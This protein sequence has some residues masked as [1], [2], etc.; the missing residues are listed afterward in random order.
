MDIDAYAAAHRGEWDRL[1]ALSRGSRPLDGA[2]A[3]ELVALYQRVATQLSVV[4]SAVPDAVVVGHL[5]SLLA[6]ARGAIAGPRVPA[7][8]EILFF[9]TD[10]FPAAVYR[11]RRWWVPTALLSL[12]GAVLMGWYVYANPSAQSQ[13]ASVDAVRGLVRPGGEFESYYTNF[14][15][16]SFGFEVWVN[17][18][19]VAA[20]TLFGGILLGVPVFIGLYDNMMNAGVQGGFM[21]AHGRL[22]VFLSLIAPHGMLELTAV[23]IAAGCGLRIAWTILSPGPRT[24]SE[25]LGEQGRILGGLAMGLVVVLLVSG[26]IEGFVTGHTSAPVRL[27]IGATAE[28]LFLVYVFVVGRRA[29]RRGATG[30]ILWSDQGDSLPSRF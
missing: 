4:R 29:A 1:S 28:I 8:R 6:T 15:P 2:E 27:T 24:R 17:N 18:A 21:A 25:A 10:N 23:F 19:W 7:W 30:D 3:D 20:L 9:F 22:G 11:A 13:L 5:S 26:T 16:G 14:G 12:L